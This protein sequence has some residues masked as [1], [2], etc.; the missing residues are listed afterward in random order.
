MVQGTIEKWIERG[1]TF[2]TIPRISMFES[3]LAVKLGHLLEFAK[4]PVRRVYKP[5][6]TLTETGMELVQG[7]PLQKLVTIRDWRNTIVTFPSI[8]EKRADAIYEYICSKS[9][10]TL[11][12]ALI[13][14]TSEAMVKDIPGVGSGNVSKIREWFGIDEALEI[15]LSVKEVDNGS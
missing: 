14:L 10:K 7:F 13:H 11:I 12:S 4:E 6:P 9:D 3:W 15:S 5:V 8:G 2:T 1:G